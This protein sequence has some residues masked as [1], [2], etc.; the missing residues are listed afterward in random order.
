MCFAKLRKLSAFISWTTFS[1]LPS[2]FSLIETLILKQIFCYSQTGPQNYLLVFSI[3]S[4]L[5]RLGS[6]YWAIFQF[7]DSYLCPRHYTV[8]LIHWVFYVSYC[9]F[10]FWNFHLVLLYIFL[11]LLKLLFVSSMC[12]IAPWDIFM[13]VLKN[14]FGTSSSSWYWHLWITFF[15]SVWDI[16]DSWYDQWFSFDTWTFW[17]L[18]SET[19]DRI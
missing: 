18:Y 12:V 10:Q 2:F 5:F 17:V 13:M 11:S 6:F 1:A 16:P 15:H 9:I 4:L 7:S 19:Q 14:P 8:A 3:F